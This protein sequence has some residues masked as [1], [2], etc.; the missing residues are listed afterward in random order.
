[1][2]KLSDTI[3]TIRT[4]G[5]QPMGFG[6]SKN[7]D[8]SDSRGLLIITV[9]Q[10][11]EN[12]GGVIL[13][14]DLTDLPA[15]KQRISTR[16]EA[17]LGVEPKTLTLDKIRSIEDLGFDFVVLQPDL[18]S[19]ASLISTSIEYVVRLPENDPAF[20]ESK[21][22]SIASLQ[23]TLIIARA[24]NEHLS[25]SELLVMRTIGLYTGVPLAVPIQSTVSAELLEVLRE[26]GVSALLLN[27][28][29]NETLTKLQETIDKIPKQPRRRKNRNDALVP[30]VKFVEIDN[31][32]QDE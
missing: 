7:S 30:P 20:S 31:D 16:T 8:N 28:A 2:F 10:F 14:D 1:M 6:F 29:T 27:N 19:A 25:L 4:Y 15:L 13:N 18:T 23:P 11:Q 9:D 22:R 32:F 21:L 12:T 5:N 17:P 26:S 24:V 3:R